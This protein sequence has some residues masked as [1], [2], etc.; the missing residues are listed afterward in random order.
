MVIR[1]GDPLLGSNVAFL[2]FGGYNAAGQISSG[3]TCSTAARSSSSARGR[4]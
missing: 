4:P 3:P 1:E 2:R